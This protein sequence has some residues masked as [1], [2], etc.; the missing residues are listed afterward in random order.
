MLDHGQ[1]KVGQ[2]TLGTTDQSLKLR[3]Y[4]SIHVLYMKCI[5]RM[6]RTCQKARANVHC[7]TRNS[8][9]VMPNEP[10]QGRTKMRL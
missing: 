8:T 9:K 5:T 10:N 3:L 2:V 4:G 6:M 7:L 1:A